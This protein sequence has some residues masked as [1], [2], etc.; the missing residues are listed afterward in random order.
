MGNNLFPETV[1]FLWVFHCKSHVATVL[2][3]VPFGCRESSGTQ[4]TSCKEVIYFFAQRCQNL[5][6][7]PLNYTKIKLRAFRSNSVMEMAYSV[8]KIS[9]FIWIMW[10]RAE[11]FIR[12]SEKFR[13]A[14][15][16]IW[17]SFSVDLCNLRLFIVLFLLVFEGLGTCRRGLR[18]SDF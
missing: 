16:G 7:I 9:V 4:D 15:L 17:T 1:F 18:I 12:S 11:L 6:E 8:H 2:F 13:H 3:V 5:P 10:G 14:S